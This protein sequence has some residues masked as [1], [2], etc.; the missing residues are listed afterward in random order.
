MQIQMNIL[1]GIQN[2]LQF[3]NDYWVVIIT[4]I[5]LIITIV[6]KAKDFFG[7]SDDEKVEIAKKQIQEI[8]LKLIS[9]AEVDY[10]EW[11]SAGS[12]KRSQVIDKIFEKYPVL[13]KVT[14]QEE[15]IKWLDEV[16]DESLKTMRE[17]FKKNEE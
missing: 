9:D 4:I 1:Q 10:D 15:I 8:M 17:I 16:I 12:I 11:T 2:F 7:K 5:G 13:S 14:N 3:I 6:K